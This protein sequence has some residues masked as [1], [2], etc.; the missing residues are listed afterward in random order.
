MTDFLLRIMCHLILQN[1]QID[2]VPTFQT[3]ILI[4]TLHFLEFSVYFI[5]LNEF[6]VE[7]RFSICLSE[8]STKKIKNRN[9]KTSRSVDLSL[10]IVIAYYISQ[11]LIPSSE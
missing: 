3:I 9:K 7:F 6:I 11:W 8:M 4:Y 2:E 1:D 5:S 10:Y